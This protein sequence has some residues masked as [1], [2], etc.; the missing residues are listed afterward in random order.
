MMNALQTLIDNGCTEDTMERI[1]NDVL[2]S[3]IVDGGDKLCCI[4]MLNDYE[5]GDRYDPSG[6]SILPDNIVD[7]PLGEYL[8]LDDDVADAACQ[9]HIEQVFWAFHP[10][11]LS[12]ATNVDEF[13]FKA[14]ADMGED[15]N[16]GVR[17]IIVGACGIYRFVESAISTDGRG[18]FLSGFDG[19]E[20]EVSV[21]GYE[22]YLYRQN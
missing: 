9:D 5:H 16:D 4:V 1:L 19:K 10:S 12:S 2:G 13:V 22:Y 11:F 17:A 21:D 3:D 20:H 15:A 6:Y 8:V 7:S 18:S 14:L